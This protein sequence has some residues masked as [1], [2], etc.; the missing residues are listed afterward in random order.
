MRGLK[1]RAQ[2]KVTKEWGYFEFPIMPYNVNEYEHWGQY[3][4]VHD[5][6]SVEIYED[7]IMDGKNNA[8]SRWGGPVRWSSFEVIK[9]NEKRTGFHPLTDHSGTSL[10]SLLVVGNIYDNPELLD[11]EVK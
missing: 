7:D 6:V 3:T 11:K 10:D 5:R 1:F 4:G 9:W 2:N 8:P